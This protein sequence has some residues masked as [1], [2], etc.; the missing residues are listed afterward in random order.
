MYGEQLNHEEW[1]ERDVL[2]KETI[3]YNA[4]FHASL[5]VPTGE[6]SLL[7][8]KCVLHVI[9]LMKRNEDRLVN[10]VW[11]ELISVCVQYMCACVCTRAHACLRRRNVSM[12][13]M[14]CARMTWDEDTFP[15]RFS[16]STESSD[17]FKMCTLEK[18][19]ESWHYSTISSHSYANLN[20]GGREGDREDKSR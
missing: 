6:Y 14:K 19:H 11:R 7:H 9:C 4:T 5:S 10:L 12:V 1:I 8:M 16:G 20:R 15:W 3:N 18:G 17:W 2:S 13:S